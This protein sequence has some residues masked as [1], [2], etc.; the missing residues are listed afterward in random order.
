[1][2]APPNNNVPEINAL[3]WRDR[4]FVPLSVAA[5]IVGVSRAS[6][7]ALEA[8]G[9]LSFSRLAGRTLVSVTSLKALIGSAEP[10]SASDRGK[11]ARAARTIASAEG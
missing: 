7:Y 6:I 9:E 8:K 4:A 11:E 10:W 5:E 3:P 1:V 2:A